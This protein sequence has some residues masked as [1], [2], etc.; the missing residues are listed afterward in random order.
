MSY[1]QA[2]VFKISSQD[3]VTNISPR[4]VKG[5]TSGYHYG[6]EQGSF[7]NIELISE[8]TADYWCG[9][10]MELKRDFPTKVSAPYASGFSL[11]FYHADDIRN[12]KFK[13]YEKETKIKNN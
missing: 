6:P 10:V 1:F 11:E 9:S 12:V 2:H 3:L 8:K 5:T 4:I 7:L 13:N